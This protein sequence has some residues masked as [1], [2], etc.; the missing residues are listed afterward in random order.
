MANDPFRDA[1]DALLSDLASFEHRPL[2]FVY[3]A[4]PWGEEGELERRTGPEAWQKRV[5][6]DLQDALLAGESNTSRL[7]TD[8]VQL[9][10]KSGHN[11]GKSALVCWITL[12]AVSTR[13]DTKGVVTA[14]T[15]KQLRLKLWAELSKWHRLFLAAPLFKVTA[16]SIQSTDPAHEKEWRIDAIPWSEDNPEAFAGLHNYGKRVLVVFD[17]ASG[18]LDKIWETIDGVM[19]EA[20]TEL[21]WLVTGN[22]TRNTGRFRE[23]FDIHGQG[24]F[25]RTYTVDSREVSF[26]NKDRIDRAI[27]LWGID[28]D[29][30][31]VRWLGEFPVAG[32][33]QLIDSETIR[34]AGVREAQSQHW[35]PLILAVDVAR[36]GQNASV[37]MFRRGKDA[38]TIPTLRWRGLSTIELGHHVAHLIAQHSPDAVFIDEGGIGSGVVDFVRHLGHSVIGVQFGSVSGIPLGGEKAANKRAEMYLSVRHWLRE[39]GAIP[40]DEDL[41][42]ELTSIEY[43]HQRKTD[44]I[45]LTPKEDM[46]ESPDWADALAMTFAYPVAKRAW[47][48]GPNKM[49]S[50][51]DPF[52]P[53]AL[54]FQG[55]SME[56]VH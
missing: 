54:P 20:D 28:S 1:Q 40:P 51:Y 38:R 16:T 45:L 34:I 37:A 10:V 29:F 42:K 32:T 43:G 35:E 5:L 24:Q 30:I 26:T 4:F 50:D 36:F 12:W 21:V 17:E 18:I 3:W 47:A 39:G 49:K 2:D 56:S 6:S 15:E 9:A 33:S 31:K 22:P 53:K 23:C 19:N 13:E 46:D 11:I 48:R 7:V 27:A 25:W 41:A 8:A 55:Q 52:G 44:S 14:N